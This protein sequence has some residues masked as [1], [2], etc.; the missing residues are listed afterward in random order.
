MLHT[1]LALSLLASPE[2]YGP[3]LYPDQEDYAS[4]GI[5]T[6][7]LDL[8]T[9]G[10]RLLLSSVTI[11]DGDTTPDVAGGNLFVTS[12]NTG[13]TAIT[14]LDNPAVG[15]IVRICGGSNINSSTIADAGNFALIQAMALALDECIVLYV[16]AD[17]DYVELARN[18]LQLTPWTSD[19][20]AA[21]YDLLNVDVAYRDAAASDVAPDDTTI[22]GGNAYERAMVNTAGAPLYLAGGVGAAN[23]TCLQATGD[24]TV[25]VFTACDS[26][27][28]T[29]TTVTEDTGTGGD[30]DCLTDDDTCCD[31]LETYVDGLGLRFQTTCVANVLWVDPAYTTLS[32][33]LTSANGV[34]GGTKFV[35]VDG[36]EGGLQTTRG[37]VAV[38]AIASITDPTTGVFW[39]TLGTTLTIGNEGHSTLSVG[40]T[41][42]TYYEDLWMDTS[43]FIALKGG[44]IYDATDDLNLGATYAPTK[45]GV[46]GSTAF[47][48]DAA[49]IS[50]EFEKRVWFMGQVLLELNTVV[51]AT[52]TD[53]FDIDW[54]NG[55]IVLLDME[56][57]DQDANDVNAPANP[58]DSAIYKIIIEQSTAGT[59]D[60]TWNAAFLWPGG[61]D[62]VLTQAN[63]ARDMIECVYADGA[64][65]CT[66][67]QAFAP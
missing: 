32:F 65:H 13:A 20:D 58:L 49:G 14:D 5:A 6:G 2:L 30:W 52:A 64:Y 38:P 16:Q 62:P 10:Y 29:T 27:G 1:L 42:V 60:L 53:D 47:G 25:L 45:G 12:A 57:C 4:G 36:A 26:T 19:V 18:N 31:A 11:A 39:D 7:D 23:A 44:R 8:D 63:N 51:C 24:Q 17:N 40:P 15:Q 33:R 9:G 46:T 3:L 54:D 66:F 43:Q 28:C 21:D 41:S 50:A 56:G 61:T 59:E 35:V 37:S 34:G 22:K 48:K 67:A 55:N